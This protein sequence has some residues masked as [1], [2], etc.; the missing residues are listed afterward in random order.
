MTV[1]LFGQLECQVKEKSIFKNLSKNK[2]KYKG[3]CF[4]KFSWYIFRNINGHVSSLSCKEFVS[5]DQLMLPCK[6]KQN[7]PY[8]TKITFGNTSLDCCGRFSKPTSSVIK[9]P[10]NYHLIKSLIN[11]IKFKIKYNRTETTDEKFEILLIW[12][13]ARRKYW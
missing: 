6:H 12:L 8:R 2:I 4:E 9:L 10:G 3:F 13:E 1:T 5:T 11:S 7:R